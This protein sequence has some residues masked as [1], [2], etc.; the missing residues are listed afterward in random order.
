MTRPRA[1]ALAVCWS[2]LLLFAIAPMLV[3]LVIALARPADTV[4]P[5]ALAADPGNFVAAATDGLYRTAFWLSLR[6]AAVSTVI[7]LLL[8]YPM[9]LAIA[10]SGERWRAWLLLALMLP[11][12]TGF[13]MRINAWI[14]MLRD[15]GW[16][17]AALA[18]LGIAQVRLLYTDAALYII[19]KGQVS[20]V[21][22]GPEG[23]GDINLATLDEGDFFGEMAL[24]DGAPRSASVTALTPTECLLLTRW[25]FYTTL[26]SDPEIAVAMLPTLSKRVRDAEEVTKRIVTT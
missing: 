26:R 19:L 5:F 1:I 10:R 11:F 20:V 8:G 7:C 4:P 2:W 14:G 18:V 12:W 15:D 25:V 9:A 22:R 6:T 16:I 17:N 24:L 3:I 21:K 23:Q 13:L